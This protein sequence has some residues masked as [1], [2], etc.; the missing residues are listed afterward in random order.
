MVQYLE[1][2]ID[3]PRCAIQFDRKEDAQYNC[4]SN[5]IRSFMQTESTLDYLIDP[6]D[7]NELAKH[8]RCHFS[9]EISCNQP[10]PNNP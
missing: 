5:D 4:Y 8:R 10:I 7:N 1:R 3:G 9:G 2:E 6:I